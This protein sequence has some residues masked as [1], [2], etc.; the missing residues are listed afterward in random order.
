MSIDHAQPRNELVAV[1]PQSAHNRVSAALPP[2]LSFRS[3]RSRFL[4]AALALAAGLTL[5]LAT[6]GAPPLAPHL[7]VRVANST[8]V[9]LTWGLANAEDAS[10]YE[11]HRDGTYLATTN[12]VGYSD[13]GVA[14]SST[15]SYHVIAINDQGERSVAT[16][17]KTITTPAARPQGRVFHVSALSGDDDGGDG[18]TATPWRTIVHSLATMNGGDTLVVHAGT[19]NESGLTPKSGSIDHWTVIRAAAGEPTP[20]VDGGFDAPQDGSERD[21]SAPVFALMRRHWIKLQG[22]DIRRGLQANVRIGDDPDFSSNIVIED[23]SFSGY[24]WSDNTAGVYLAMG[25]RQVAIRRCRFVGAGPSGHDNGIQIFRG[26]GSLEIS[27]CEFSGNQQGIYFKHGGTGRREQI[28]VNNF[29]HD[30]GHYAIDAC[31]DRVRI[32]NNLAVR[33]KTAVRIYSS[34]GVPAG[35][36]CVVVHN[37]FHRNTNS[38]ILNYQDGDGAEFNRLQDNILHGYD[39]VYGEY[40]IWPETDSAAPVSLLHENTSDYNLYWSETDVRVFD[41]KGDWNLADWQALSSQDVHSLQQVPV[42]VGAVANSSTPADFALAAGSP[43][44]N[45]ASD[46][47]DM[48]ANLAMVGWRAPVFS[49][50]DTWRTA[51]WVGADLTSDVVSGPNADPDHSGLTNFARYAFAL[52]A[53]GPVAS[54]VVTGT[55]ETIGGRVLTLTFPRRSDAADLNYTAEAST[56]LVTW[57]PVPDHTYTPGTPATVTAEDIVPLTA[58]SA[59]RRFLRLRITQQ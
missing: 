24:V 55:A 16:D 54:P 43:G 29:I 11:I 45:A 35:D 18:S 1:V 12:D 51:N 25:W 23:C 9:S 15:H 39:N 10:L 33:N 37:T 36:H 42:Y 2:P 48:G 19:Y 17:T 3:G 28:V 14:P 52:P 40:A 4:S 41:C 58:T 50:Y 32:V 44:K 21:G 47:T 59:P 30:N 8:Q 38:V 27:H 57:L 26:D 5:P 22:L 7:S 34:A 53:R 31:S 46:G 6:P 56:D 13:F 20:V 49:T